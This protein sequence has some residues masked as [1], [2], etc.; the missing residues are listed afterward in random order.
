MRP[1][2]E[3]KNLEQLKAYSSFCKSCSSGESYWF[4]KKKNWIVWTVGQKY[5]DWFS[6]ALWR[7]FEKVYNGI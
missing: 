6:T 4:G 1:W 2:L 5:A 3:G 7:W